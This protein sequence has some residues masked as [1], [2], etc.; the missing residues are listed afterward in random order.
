MIKKF[1]N[2]KIFIES[3]IFFLILISAIYFSYIYFIANIN[4]DWRHNIDSEILW[5]YNVLLILSGKEIEFNHYGFFYFFL[6]FKF[7]QI[8]DYFNLLKVNNIYSLNNDGNFTEK[9]ENI[10][11]AGRWFNI[12]IIYIGILCAYI[13]FNSLSNNKFFSCILTLIFMLTPGMLQQISHAR[14]DILSSTLFFISFF[15]LIKFSELKKKINYI[16]FLIFFLLA[17]LT[18]V[19]A[20][21]FLFA[22]IISSLYF[23]KLENKIDREFKY[24]SWI[25]ILLIIFVLYCLIY[26][27]IFHRHAKFSILFLYSQI[28]FLNLYFYFLFKNLR[29]TY[30]KNLF[31]TSITFLI[32]IFIILILNNLTYLGSNSVR[33]TFFEPMEIRMYIDETNLKGM[34][35]IT[36]DITKNLNYFYLLLKKIIFGF[37]TTSFVVLS[38]FNSNSLLIYINIFLI[39]YFFLFQKSK[40]DILLLLPVL[41]FFIIN[42]INDIRGQ[43]LE[44]YLT[45]SEFLLF[46]PLCVFFKKSDKVFKKYLYLSLIIILIIPTTLNPNLFNKQYFAKI[47]RFK[48]LCPQFTNAYTKEILKEK[49][50]EICY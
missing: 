17:I 35:V 11:L 48:D 6:E 45:F 7:F 31:F 9:L 44:L 27:L 23:V 26:P 36:L 5:P 34:D 30:N 14:V 40:K 32:I 12:L 20:Y 15:Y 42:G 33:L 41:S 16:L 37:F 50:I 4:G 25:N 46:V 2:S 10:I 1:K 3:N 43:G 18:K 38:K 8:L 22:L 49:I 13:I 19:Q 21:L 29:N 47:D 39:F 24:N 28:T